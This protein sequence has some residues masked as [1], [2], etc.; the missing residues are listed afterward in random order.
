[1]GLARRRVFAVLGLLAVTTFNSRVV[2]SSTVTGGGRGPTPPP[3]PSGEPTYT[4][5]PG[6]TL[7][8]QG[9][10]SSAKYSSLTAA[11]A[12]D[13]VYNVPW[14]APHPSPVQDGNPVDPSS[15]AILPTGGKSGGK[16]IQSLFLPIASGQNGGRWGITGT[17]MTVSNSDV[18]FETYWI[19][20]TGA[21]VNATAIK[22]HQIDDADTGGARTQ[23]S[24]R[25]TQGFVGHDPAQVTFFQVLAT[26]EADDFG[27]QPFG[28]YLPDIFDGSYHR[29]T[30]SQAGHASSANKDGWVK[31]WIDG[32]LV[33]WVQQ[34]VVGVTPTGGFKAWC[35][36][37]VVDYL[38]TNH[39]VG[40]ADFY[41]NDCICGPLTAGDGTFQ[42]ALDIDSAIVWK[43]PKP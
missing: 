3:V 28:P 20:G 29:F 21:P 10:G 12:A 13:G 24:T 30:W 26:S 35:T 4:G 2:L 5:A 22:F 6:Q 1:M 31:M 25:F 37:A 17:G 16:A 32:T 8:A 9:N 19:K 38:R 14:F 18:L 7:I 41:L 36:Q 27:Q 11:G 40:E 15:A 43:E 39:V 42:L 33:L 23:T 34:T